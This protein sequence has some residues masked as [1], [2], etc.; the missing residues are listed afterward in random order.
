MFSS[1]S[2]HVWI[3][4][5]L[6]HIIAMIV[7]RY[8]C[9]HLGRKYE[10]YWIAKRY[11]AYQWQRV[12]ELS[13]LHIVGVHFRQRLQNRSIRQYRTGTTQ[14][15]MDRWPN[16]V[17][18]AK[19]NLRMDFE[20]SKVPSNISKIGTSTKKRWS[21]N[22]FFLR[23]L[24]L[25]DSVSLPNT[26]PL[27]VNVRFLAHHTIRPATH[28]WSYWFLNREVFAVDWFVF[29]TFS[30]SKFILDSCLRSICLWFMYSVSDGRSLK[31]PPWI[32]RWTGLTAI[33]S[34]YSPTHTSAKL[35]HS[36]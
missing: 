28:S 3:P 4:R 11:S 33:S 26:W 23:T 29:I 25:I 19:L 22:G 31:M 12:S 20:R 27:R 10:I 6:S 30:L 36:I 18:I 8:K 21:A 2:N 13:I 16:I 5:W 17:H 7:L 1:Q 9:D 34:N 35:H 32:S 14:N 24:P 15:L